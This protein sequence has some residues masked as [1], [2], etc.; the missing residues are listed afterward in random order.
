MARYTTEAEV[1]LLSRYAAVARHGIVEIGAL[2]GETTKAMSL[3]ASVPMYAIDPII[4]D[5]MDV[6]LVGSRQKILTNMSHYSRFTFIEDFSFNVVKTFSWVFD[7][8]FIDGDH[9]YDAVSRDAKDWIPLLEK[10]GYVVFHDS[11]PVTS[12][13]APFKGW[14]GCV[15]IVKE[16]KSGKHADLNLE[17]VENV[18]TANVFR[19]GKK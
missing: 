16:I 3:V 11:D 18:D 12:T 9:S 7:M 1:K 2:D 19:K 14:P 5:S 8:L 4:P 13:D 10:G 6:N 15:Q 17:W